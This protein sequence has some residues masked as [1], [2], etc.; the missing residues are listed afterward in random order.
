MSQH[1][2]YGHKAPFGVTTRVEAID[3]EMFFNVLLFEEEASILLDGFELE[4]HHHFGCAADLNI[5]F[6]DVNREEEAVIHHAIPA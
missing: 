3:G 5:T 6:V 1:K 4:P 2:P